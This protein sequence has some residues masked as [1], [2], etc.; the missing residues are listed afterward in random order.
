[1]KA[2]ARRRGVDL[3]VVD[4]GD[5][6]DGN[7]FVDGEPDGHV[8][9]CVLLTL[10]SK[11]S[12]ESDEKRTRW[13]A[14]KY[15]SEMPYDVITTGNHELYKYPVALS[16]YQNLARHYGTRYVASNVNL[17]IETAVGGEETVP[18]GARFAKFTTEQ[19]R[20]V[21]A[22]GPLFFFKGQSFILK[23]VLPVTD[24][25]AAAH[26]T[27]IDVQPPHDMVKEAWFREAIAEPPSFFLLGVLYI[28]AT[29]RQYFDHPPIQLDT[30]RS[31]RR[32][33]ASG[34]PSSTRFAPFTRRSRS[35][36]L[37]GIIM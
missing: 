16:T 5:R 3:L 30:C 2:E 10:T 14:M 4:S 23:D 21:T 28:I 12:P 20:N 13:S 33:T 8:K 9:G 18:T 35:S 11:Y 6:V 25:N 37:V 17:T 27:G 15:F 34:A 26:A 19:G 36:S 31:R 29:L 24:L 32:P 22:L 7:G 1:M